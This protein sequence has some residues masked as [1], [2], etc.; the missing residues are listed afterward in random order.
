[1]RSASCAIVAAILCVTAQADD[2][3]WPSWRGPAF[4]GVS[5]TGNPPTAWSETENIRWKIDVPGESSSTPIIWGN[6]MFIQAAVWDK[7]EEEEGGRGR[8]MQIRKPDTPIQFNVVCINRENGAIIWTTTVV[9]AIPHESR[10][11]TGS[12]APYSPVTDGEKLW[13]S[14]GSRGLYCLDL[15]GNVLWKHDLIEM[16]TRNSFGE[17]SSPAIAGDAIIVIQDHEGDSQISAFNKDTGEPMWSKARD[18]VT[19]W[20]TPLAVEVDGKVQ[21]VT[22]ATDRIRSYDAATGDIVWECDGLTTNSIPSPVEGFG[23][24]YCMSGF[25][26]YVLRAIELGHEGDLTGTDAIKW[27]ATSGTPYVASPLLYDEYLYFTAD[28]AA[29]IS[30]VN[31][32]TGEPYY[33]EERI[34]GLRE[35]YAS[36]VGAGGKIY[37]A[38]RNGAVAVIEKGETFNVLAVNELDDTFDASPVVAGD[39]LYLNGE[40]FLYC[41][42]E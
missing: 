41:I 28:R 4:D 37:V 32:M 40:N 9:E 3:I 5:E 27:E 24:V 23:N 29:Q 13:A 25:R 1:M 38:D 11:P 16:H 39:V 31:A 30:C 18:E 2:A 33:Q 20:G 34:R 10:H 22:N 26:G 42:A 6:K 19:S 17:G 36:P 7:P 12:F 15:N 21:V 35:I 14:F 8:R